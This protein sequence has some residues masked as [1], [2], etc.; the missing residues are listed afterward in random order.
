MIASSGFA[1]VVGDD[2]VALVLTAVTDE[3]ER[4]PVGARQLGCQLRPFDRI[5]CFV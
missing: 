1:Q 2:R 4:H 5:V 3:G